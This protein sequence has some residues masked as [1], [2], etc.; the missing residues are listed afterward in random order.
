MYREMTSTVR[1]E[2]IPNDLIGSVQRSLNILEL[3]A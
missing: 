1:L 2:A 3:L